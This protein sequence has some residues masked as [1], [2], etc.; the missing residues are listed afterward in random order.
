MKCGGRLPSGKQ[1]NG[2]AGDGYRASERVYMGYRLMYM[3]MVV[4]L[5][6]VFLVMVMLVMFVFTM[7]VLMPMCNSFMDM[8]MLMPLPV[9]A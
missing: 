3:V 5:P 4:W 1:F 9:K 7:R 6:I 8:G 2:C